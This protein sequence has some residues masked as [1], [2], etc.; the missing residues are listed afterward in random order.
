[1]LFRSVDELARSGFRPRVCIVGSGP[2]GIS[3]ALR[4]QERNVACLI[5]EAGGFDFSAESQD[6]YRGEVIGDHYHKLHEARLRQFGGTSG[7]WSGWVCPLDASDFE[8]RSHVPNSGWPI[9]SSDLDVYS[10]AADVIVE[11]VPHQSDRPMTEDIDYIH[12][13]YSPPVR[14]GAKYRDAILQ[15]KSIG[16]LI[17]TPVLE[18]VPG[19][20]RVD[21]IKVSQG[22]GVTSEIKVDQVCVCTGGIENSRLLLWSNARHEGKVVPHAK[23]LGR[24]WM[25]HPVHVLA[26]VITVNG[27]EKQ[28][29]QFTP[30]NWMFAP[31]DHAKTGFG[32]GGAH[33]WMRA[34]R[35]ESNY[36]KELVH[37]A[38]CM[39]PDWSNR[40]LR[41]VGKEYH[42]GGYVQS[43]FEQFPYPENRIELDQQNT[44]ALG[45]PRTKLFW[46]KA[47]SERK[48][49]MITTRLLGEALIKKDI[50]RL[51]MRNFLT[52][53]TAWPLDDQTGGWHHL[54]G[55]R[56][57][58]S[59]DTGVVDKNC[60]VFGMDNL[61]VSGGSVFT[62]GGHASPT[63]NIVK[64]ALRLGDHLVGKLAAE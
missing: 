56:M 16:L 60:K 28:F 31:S 20:E 47:D 25:E 49:A 26:D 51:R 9:R 64:L 14:F 53:G 19:R 43:E 48:T 12:Y 54:G 62:T 2:A 13:R 44:D 36:V 11:V 61:Y 29:E 7:H 8:R 24:Y 18:L 57:S 42:C 37:E 23:T 6:V 63:Y 3:V 21:A 4:L 33:I 35:P 22:P 52:Y 30:D 58:D 41:H 50:G 15:S 55:T 10:K 34:H 39:A 17:N 46:K 32:I 45:V 5:V 38:V 1:M 27:Y 40:V 59:P